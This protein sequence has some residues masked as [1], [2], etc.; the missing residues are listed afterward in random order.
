MGCHYVE[1]RRLRFLVPVKKGRVEES[2][3]TYE[4]SALARNG[5]VLADGDCNYLHTQV[6][7]VHTGGGSFLETL[8]IID[9]TVKISQS[10]DTVS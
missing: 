2:S 7:R 5:D 8:G 9:W 6:R 10:L 1:L 3:A 4:N